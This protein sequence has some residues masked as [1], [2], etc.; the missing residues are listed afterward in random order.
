MRLFR[1]ADFVRFV[2]VFS[3]TSLPRAFGL[4][5]VRDLRPGLF[6]V[7]FSVCARV[8]LDRMSTRRHCT[9]IA[10]YRVRS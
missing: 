6:A 5:V 4:E 8:Y 2:F 7:V 1:T 3:S 10:A 9:T